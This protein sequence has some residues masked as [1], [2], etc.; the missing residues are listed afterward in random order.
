MFA[1]LNLRLMK[2]KDI[3]QGS[4]VYIPPMLASTRWPVGVKE[5]QQDAQYYVSTADEGA[6]MQELKDSLE[7]F[8]ETAP[9]DAPNVQRL[10]K[11]IRAVAYQER[12]DSL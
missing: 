7:A 6:E 10:I 2:G 4:T 9:L 11:A 8:T 12:V 1:K 3:P 5:S